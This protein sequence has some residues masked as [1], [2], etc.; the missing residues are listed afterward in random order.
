MKIFISIIIV[1]YNSERFLAK[2]LKPLRGVPD[3][4][5]IVV[6]NNSTDKKYLESEDNDNIRILYLKDNLGFGRANNLGLNEKSTCAT[7]I[8]FLNHDVFLR[9]EWLYVLKQKLMSDVNFGIL[10]GPLL[11]YDI[12]QLRAT[13]KYDSLG[14]GKTVY[15]KWFDIGQ[16]ETIENRVKKDIKV[17]GVCGALMVMKMS[18]VDDLK[19][20]DELFDSN[21]FMYK[22]D[23]D[24]SIRVTNLGLD[25]LIEDKLWAYHCRG[26]NKDRKTVDKKWKI[27][28]AKNELYMNYKFKNITV[29]Y[30]L[31]KL[32]YVFSFE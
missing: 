20:D 23:I 24:L 19:N 9:D 29:F 3:V 7:H 14:L 27:M 26:W 15:G 31:I 22:E 16:G 1:T 10:S 28:S 25:H 8:V 4:E 6:D 21:Y 13:G 2:C 32:I 17:A 18:L 12:E 11:G 30:S 5:V